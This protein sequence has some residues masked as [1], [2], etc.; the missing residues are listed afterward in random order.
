[1]IFSKPLCRNK[2]PLNKSL[3]R[4][5]PRSKEQKMRNNLS[6]LVTFILLVVGTPTGADQTQCDG[7]LAFEAALPP[8]ANTLGNI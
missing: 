2:L 4:R 7:Y 8:T 3:G 1:M 5:C 6:F